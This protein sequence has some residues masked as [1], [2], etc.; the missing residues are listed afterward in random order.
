MLSYEDYM[1]TDGPIAVEPLI[2]LNGGLHGKAVPKE[3]GCNTNVVSKQ[4]LRKNRKLFKIAKVQSCVN[5]SQKYT[6]EESVELIISRTLKLG[7]HVYTSNWVVAYGRYDVLLG[8][9]WHFAHNPRIDYLQR[10]VQVG[11]D[12]F[13]VDSFGDKR[14]AKSIKDI[15]DEP[16][17]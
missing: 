1:S 15:S 8:M 10:V 7:T 11:S 6:Y 9:P 12:E 4:C 3:D 5:H 13:P 2:V 14:V 16:Q 17:C